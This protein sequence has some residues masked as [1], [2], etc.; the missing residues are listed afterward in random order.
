MFEIDN[1]PRRLNCSKWSM[2]IILAVLILTSLPAAA[3]DLPS[4]FL[5]SAYCDTLPT[6]SGT[7]PF[8][9]ILE[10]GT[11]PPGLQLNPWGTITGTPL[12][13]GGFSFDVAAM[14]SNDVSQTS[15]YDLEVLYDA[16]NVTRISGVVLDVAT[17]DPISDAQVTL[18][19][20]G[21]STTTD[22]DG[23]YRIEIPV[24]TV[25]LLVE[26]DGYAPIMHRVIGDSVG[27]GGF[28]GCVPTADLTPLNPPVVVGPMGGEFTVVGNDGKEYTLIIPE[29]ALLADTSITITPIASLPSTSDRMMASPVHLGPSGLQFAQPIQLILPLDLKEDPASV[30]LRSAL[31][32]ATYGGWKRNSAPV[33]VSPDSSSATI[34]LDMFESTTAVDTRNM[35]FGEVFA[36]LKEIWKAGGRDIVLIDSHEKIASIK[37]IPLVST[38]DC[39]EA[40]T[41]CHDSWSETRT[42]TT[43]WTISGSVT[44]EVKAGVKFIVKAELKVGFTVGGSYGESST[45][46]FTSNNS[47]DCP[48]KKLCVITKRWDEETWK[49]TGRFIKLTGVTPAGDIQFNLGA[50]FSV[51]YTLYHNFYKPVEYPCPEGK[52]VV[53]RVAE[54]ESIKFEWTKDGTVMESDKWCYKY[55][56]EG[57][58]VITECVKGKLDFFKRHPELIGKA[59]K[60]WFYA[61]DGATDW[62]Q[63]IYSS[64][65]ESVVTA[66]NI[67]TGSDWY[68]R[69]LD[70]L[71]DVHW[72]IPDIAPASGGDSTAAIY[73]AVNLDLYLNS[74]PLG[75]NNG[76]WE[77]KQTLGELGVEVVNGQV[78]G[79]E[80]IYWAT[81]EFQ[82]N[83]SSDWGFTPIGGETTFLNTA[84]YPTDLII[85]EQHSD[86]DVTAG[87]TIQIERS[88][89]TLQ[90]QHE[91]VD[92]TLD[93][94]N[95]EIGGFDFLI[96]Y[97]ASALGL[98]DV[99][100][101]PVFYDPAPGGCGWE[102]FTYRYGPFGNCGDACPSGM[103]RVV[104]LAETNNGA[105]YPSCFLPDSLPATLFTLDFMVSNDRTLECQYVPIRFFWANCG[106]NTI[107][108]VTGDTLFVSNHVY[109]LE[110]TE[111]TAPTFGFPTY[112]GVQ[113]ECLENGDPDKPIAMQFI[114]YVNGGIDIICADSIDLR[115]DINL[116]GIR[117]EISDAVMFVKYFV[118]G[119]VAFGN[120]P[121]GSIAASDCNAD[122]IT[123]SVADLVY[124][125]RVIT[126]SAPPIPKLAPIQANVDLT[127]GVLSI[128]TEIGAAFVQ[129]DGHVTP[130]LLAENMEMKYG[131]D[132]D[133]DVTRI[134]IY[135]LK[136]G[137]WFQGR[138]LDGIGN[139][140][141]RLEMAT[142]DGTPVEAKLLPTQFALHQNYP[143]PFNPATT[144]SFDVPTECEY[145]LVILNVLGQAVTSFEGHAEPG[146]VEVRWDATSYASGVYLYRL[147]AG[148][149][150][151]TKKMVLL[152]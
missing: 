18:F 64:N 78:E 70:S 104:G 125:L 49:M 33:L 75:F 57:G 126:G 101:G 119:L 58:E 13:I 41:P 137:Q 62:K 43:D 76:N 34:E 74:N 106:D 47:Y 95:S 98:M 63:T 146:V 90:G 133:N 115:D 17:G 140:S 72:R 143:N 38:L 40:S 31:F 8:Y 42:S 65:G 71:P 2:S 103:V 111:I 20:V 37:G 66:G 138:F 56:V 130:I 134:L 121:A 46:S 60:F 19:G 68:F 110:G 89:G 25:T 88:H 3:E 4:G 105:N 151:V 45:K 7:P 21:T 120:H 30:H 100:P 97:D 36:K 96:A 123:L 86:Q 113:Q 148:S 61:P 32:N 93:D 24:G 53:D 94:C 141:V 48:P 109:D 77:V 136:E 16:A 127:D 118:V 124:L 128:D 144:I 99:V 55:Q 116:N 139:C 84:L 117:D 107:S 54:G 131:H 81:T 11:L 91:F 9:Y 73:T 1:L 132:A 59:I 114:D 92:V 35:N 129:V 69:D 14:D 26:R 79:L 5:D 83:P 80:G 12:A 147:T 122:G 6:P 51:E 108:D 82:F 22:I 10:T 15:N 29:N 142:Y 145:E 67:K 149:F 135:S 112:F 102:Y 23:S 52:P 44:T 150:T 85:L 39:C 50:S 28:H 152:K 27:S 87:A